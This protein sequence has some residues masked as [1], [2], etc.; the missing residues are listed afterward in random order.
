MSG[1]KQLTTINEQ[2]TRLTRSTMSFGRA[3]GQ[4]SNTECP[5]T[6]YKVQKNESVTRRM[7]E[8]ETWRREEVRKLGNQ[9]VVSSN[10]PIYE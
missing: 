6:K 9:Y 10:K 1:D 4:V 3:V 2:R 8:A 5:I 7:G